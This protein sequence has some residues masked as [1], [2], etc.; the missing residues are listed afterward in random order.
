MFVWRPKVRLADAATSVSTKPIHSIEDVDRRYVF[1]PFTAPRRHEADGGHMI[2]RGAG[3]VLWDSDDRAYL[4]AMAGLWC[5]NVGYGRPEIAEALR[6]ADRAAVVLPRV[7]V[8]GDR[9]AGAARRAGDR[10]WRGDSGSDVEGLL[11]QQRLRR[12]RH[13][14]EARLVLQQRARPPG[15]EEDHLA[16]RAATTASPSCPQG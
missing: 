5:V 16:R 10:E 7:L 2:V 11:R 14:G 9:G 12:E 3:C 1:H 13:A 15:E 8:D 6:D 4:D